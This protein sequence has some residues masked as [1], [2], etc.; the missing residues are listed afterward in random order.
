MI[1]VRTYKDALPLHHAI[2]NKFCLLVC[3]CSFF[4]SCS[5]T[6][7]KKYRIAFSQC[8]GDD[9][10]RRRMLADMKREMAFHPEI[11]FIYTDAKDNSQLQAEQVRQMINEHIDLL[12]ISPNE[13]QP[14]TGVVE[15]AFNKGIP[16]IVID[17]TIASELYTSFIG[18][19]NFEVGKMAGDYAANLLHNKGNII[20]VI[21][22]PGSTPA[23]ARQKGFRE[24]ISKH[25]AMTITAEVYGNWLKDDAAKEL[26]KIKDK[27]LQAD[28][29]FAHNDVMAL[30]TYSICKQLGIENKV[31]ILGVDGQPGPGSGLELVSN[32][33]I[34]ASMLYPTGGEEAIRTAFKILNG[35]SFNKQDILQTLVIDST[36][37]RPMQLQSAKIDEQQKDI[38]KQ[39]ALLTEQRNIYKGQTTFL[40]VTFAALVLALLLGVILLFAWR[41]NRKI[42]KRLSASNDEISNQKNQLMEMTAKAKE[43]TDA[44]FNFFTNI[45]HELR[46]PLTLILAP[47]EDALTHT[48]LH[49]SIKNNLEIVHK[50]AL[51]LLRL[52]NQLM[53][54][55]KI[56]QNKMKL[57]ASKNNLSHFVTDI[58]DSFREMAKKKNI[59]LQVYSRVNELPVW[60]DV[61]M[62]DKVM[63]NLLSNAFKFT[64]EEGF[65]TVTTG[66]SKSGNEAMITIEDTGVGMTTEA[67]EHA[68][69][70]FYQEN[71]TLYKGSGL[72]LSLSKELIELHHGSIEVES[73]KWKG[74]LFTIYLPLGSSHLE[75]DEM[76]EEAIANT[77]L[78]EDLKIYASDTIAT[79]FEETDEAITHKEHSVLLIE[80]NND[81]LHFLKCRLEQNFDVYAA[82]TGPAG[83]M[84]THEV[85]PDLIVCD[86]NLPGKDGFSITQTLKEDIRSSHIPIVILTASGSIEKQITSLQVTADAFITKPFNVTYLE[87]TIKSLLKS[88]KQLRDHYTSEASYESR[89]GASKIDRKFINEFTAIVE[90]N[91]ANDAFSIEDICKETH[92]SRIQLNRKIKALLGVHVND[93][94][95]NVRLQKAKYLLL[96]E[97]LTIAEVAYKVGFA[98]QAYFA[99]VFKS[100]L[101]VTPSEFKEKAKV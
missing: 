100:K 44:K 84:L 51:R 95:L 69:D 86:V 2:A 23:I 53:D 60:F 17:R 37:V 66:K 39:Q 92:I 8:T 27:L 28:L 94:I 91:I 54:F 48:K 87:E 11:D 5:N 56:E 73:E 24:S 52:V 36:N 57:R 15:D 61:N 40:Y 10:W 46:T 33:L 74:T 78:Y 59:T 55:R 97:D 18:A 76:V 99:T 89:N 6:T 64:K 88:R 93:Y 62:M 42:N 65:V 83:L 20:E 9:N 43:A 50:N 16:V 34:N 35:E 80:D 67:K 1:A 70:L 32:K 22:R 4:Y 71:G 38:E 26:I 96:H 82:D 49:F 7:T 79:R 90:K 75:A 101:L 58:A 72:G 13:A 12:I 98:S 81:L 30:G 19:D 77:S 3:F 29:V 45:S 14:L 21:G 63:F 25:P 85:V 31:K 41:N 47:L 68:F